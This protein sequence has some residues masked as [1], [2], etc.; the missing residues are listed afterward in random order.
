MRR[1]RPLKNKTIQKKPEIV[2]FS[3]RGRRGRPGYVELRME[4]FEAVRLADHIGL[5]QK[6]SAHFM[7]ISQQTFSRI[8]RAAR[9]KIAG[10]ITKGEIIKIAALMIIAISLSGCISI[11]IPNQIPIPK[12]LFM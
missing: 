9:R 6:E 10:A 2:Q 3:P 12:P 7:K 1:G 8:I 11:P 5:D 4:E